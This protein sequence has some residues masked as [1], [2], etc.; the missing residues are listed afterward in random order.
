V[1]KIIIAVVIAV[2]IPVVISVMISAMLHDSRSL[3]LRQ[4]VD[5]CCPVIPRMLEDVGITN[6]TVNSAGVIRE[7]VDLVRNIPGGVAISVHATMKVRRL[8]RE[9]RDV[10]EETPLGA[11]SVVRTVDRLIGSVSR[12]LVKNVREFA[13]S[14]VRSFLE[15]VLLIVVVRRGHHRNGKADAEHWHDERDAWK[16][17]G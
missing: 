14:V 12:L 16:T 6:P 2:A 1:A 7:M 3:H 15:P 11:S 5:H 10:V 17:H 9:V 4:D 8:P 13:H